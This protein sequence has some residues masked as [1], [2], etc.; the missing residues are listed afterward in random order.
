MLAVPVVDLVAGKHS[1][2]QPGPSADQPVPGDHAGV[3]MRR[4]D[5]VQPSGGLEPDREWLLLLHRPRHDRLRRPDT[6]GPQRAYGDPGGAQPVRLLA[7]HPRRD[8]PDR[9]VLQPRPGGGGT[10]GQGLP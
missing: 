6:D 5:H 10:R 3:H 9:H 8:G 7:L 4:R 1:G 2:S